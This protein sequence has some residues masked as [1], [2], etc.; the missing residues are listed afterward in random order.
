MAH[1]TI[2]LAPHFSNFCLRPLQNM[3][4]RLLR[5]SVLKY[6]F[7]YEQHFSYFNPDYLTSGLTVTSLVSVYCIMKNDVHQNYRGCLTLVHPAALGVA[8]V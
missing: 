5:T 2:S 1:V 4:C 3:A 6:V 7:N 8:R